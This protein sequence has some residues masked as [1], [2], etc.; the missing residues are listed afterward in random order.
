LREVVE[1]A[2][3]EG[4]DL[5][6]EAVDRHAGFAQGLEPDSF[7]SLYDDMT[8]GRRM[9]LEALHGELVRR[10]DRHGLAVPVSRAVYAFLRPWALSNA[11]GQ[12][13]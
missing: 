8:R 3:A 10:A 1:V 12:A 13:R 4:I 7:S 2:G 11:S 6:Q 5:G 9:E